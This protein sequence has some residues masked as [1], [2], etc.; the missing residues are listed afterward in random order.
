MTLN[1][2]EG[3]FMKMNLSKIIF[4]MIMFGTIGTAIGA[5]GLAEN[6]ELEG[7]V[8]LK[9]AQGKVR[10]CQT[11]IQFNLSDNLLTVRK[12]QLEWCPFYPDNSQR[13]YQVRTISTTVGTTYVGVSVEDPAFHV[14]LSFN[15]LK[16]VIY[17]AEEGESLLTQA[18]KEF[19]EN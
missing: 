1:K 15:T 5:T 14:R 3:D 11:Q 7:T 9:S 16:S 19:N 17:F 13:T 12:D 6:G 4:S 10:S 8:K 18:S 2:T